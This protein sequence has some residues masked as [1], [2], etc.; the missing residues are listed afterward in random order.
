MSLNREPDVSIRNEWANHHATQAVKDE[1]KQF[2]AHFPPGWVPDVGDRKDLPRIPREFQPPKLRY[3]PKKLITIDIGIIGAGVAGLFAAKVLDYL[4]YQLFVRARQANGHEG[5]NP[6][7]DE[8]YNEYVIGNRLPNMLFFK[9]QIFEAAG[10]ERVGGRLFTYEF[11]EP[12]G[13]HDYYDVGAMRFPDNPVM[14]RTFDLF[15][16]LGMEVTDLRTNPNAPLGSIIP[17]Y[18][19]NDD[20]YQFEPWCYNGINHWG[21]Y[22]EINTQSTNRDPFNMSTHGEIPI[23]IRRHSPGKVMNA[24][25]QPFREA[26]RRDEQDRPRGRRGWDMLMEYDTYSTRQF[27]GRTP[28]PRPADGGGEAEETEIPPPPYNYETIQWME[29]FNG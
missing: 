23:D 8:F 19:Q 5:P 3:P 10:E 9:Y 24:A 6:T 18:M 2:Q 26:L 27:L 15:S 14:T 28:P 16:N 11:G 29:T 22:A 13:P 20:P 17:Y 12:R 4:N 25:I 1:L 21:S 7:P